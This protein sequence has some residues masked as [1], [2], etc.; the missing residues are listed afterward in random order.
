M[1]H[2]LRH[3]RRYA[4][5]RDE[6]DPIPGRGPR[7]WSSRAFVATSA[8]AVAALALAPGTWRPVGAT[9]VPG[10]ASPA[11][12][13]PPPAAGAAPAGASPQGAAPAPAPSTPASRPASTPAPD[14]A[15]AGGGGIGGAI[16]G[17]VPATLADAPWVAAIAFSSE[18]DGYYAQFCGGSLIGPDLVL[19]AAHCV[20][21]PDL[22][23]GQVDV[24]LGRTRLSASG[25][26]RIRVTSISVHPGYSLT[27]MRYDFALLRLSRPSA[28]PWIALADPSMLQ[29]GLEAQVV[30]WGCTSTLPDG[31]CE[32]WTDELLKGSTNIQANAVCAPSPGFDGAT[33]LCARDDHS[34]QVSCQGDSG[35][36]L[37]VEADGERYLAGVVSHG[38]IGCSP[39]DYDVYARAPAALPWLGQVLGG[40]YWRGWDIAR[41]VA[42]DPDGWGPYLLDGWGG[43]HPTGL[44]PRLSGTPYWRGW[45]IARGLALTGY[46]RGYVLDGWGGLHRFGGAPAASGAPYWRGWD[47]ARGVAVMEGT[48]QGYVLDGWGGLHRFGGAPALAGGPYW[49]GWDIA[50]D[51][52]LLPGGEGGYVLDGWGGLHRF[53]NAPPV[54]G[55][56]YWKGWDIARGVTLAPDGESGI[57]VDGWGGRH[58]FTIG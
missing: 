43:V 29:V 27:H 58:T 54:H 44:A 47:I 22:A 25:G 32:E 38:P 34:A 1:L 55:G 9:P 21:D 33:M 46:R 51:V 6:S 56:P 11:P 23:P 42:Y 48:A 5:R 31:S 50:R 7:R 52:A 24:I 37:T 53:G 20:T 19:T 2:R 16:V 3:P 15:P 49:R 57:V 14:R 17:G 30:G 8:L 10:P 36:G 12:T 13:A 18:P 45:D 40:P 4:T 39:A 26:E 28:Q 41:S 35:G